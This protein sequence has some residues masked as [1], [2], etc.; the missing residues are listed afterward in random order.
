MEIT[1]VWE[2]CSVWPQFVGS[3]L[4]VNEPFSCLVFSGLHF[5][6]H[7]HAAMEAIQQQQQKTE[8]K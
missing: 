4:D 2:E 7:V 3:W 6:T 1:F 5:K 8:R